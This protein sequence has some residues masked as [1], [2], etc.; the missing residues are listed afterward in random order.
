MR[1]ARSES[2]SGD[3]AF[4]EAMVEWSAKA[5]SRVGAIIRDSEAGPLQ[6]I[7]ALYGLRGPRGE[8]AGDVG[9]GDAEHEAMA[10]V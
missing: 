8:E 5:D 10:C 9:F 7:A 1:E 6:A 4:L 2:G 3:R